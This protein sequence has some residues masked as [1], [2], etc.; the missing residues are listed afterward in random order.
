MRA[1]AVAFVALTL[2]A[3]APAPA[4]AAAAS[5]AFFAAAGD[6][7]LVRL[8]GR[9]LPAANQ[10][11]IGDWAGISAEVR[12]ALNATGG[13]PFTTLTALLEDGCAGGNKLAV[14]LSAPGMTGGRALRVATLYTAPAASRYVLF[15][16]PARLG[17]AGAEAT[18]AVAKAVEARFTQCAGTPASPGGALRLLGFESD[19]P[20][21]PAPPAP[22]RRLLVLGD[23][24]SSGDLLECCPTALGCANALPLANTLWA[25]DVTLTYGSLA[26]AALG[27]D[28]QTISWGGIGAAAG[29]VPA[30]TWP[31]LPD[32][33]P[34]TLAWPGVLAGGPGVAPLLPYN[35]SAFAPAGVVANLGTN[36]GAGGR[37]ANATFAALFVARYAAMLELVADAA[38]A[39]GGGTR[40]QLFVGVGPMTADYGAAAAAV[41]QKLGAEGFPATLLN[42]TL[43]SGRCGCGH[44]SA[45]DHAELAAAVVP[46]IRAALGW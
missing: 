15:S 11:A 45:Q 18:F 31:T 43:A 29:D 9:W 30:W 2:L 8:V 16:S 44:P 26:A 33:L 34:W 40:P 13:P 27:A 42:L 12:V 7:S 21:L 1:S 38:A 35:L 3:S 14:T 37:F 46:V 25:D 19:A 24:I 5:G 23:S 22:A 20:F 39:A 28:A 36:D 41:V 10:S 4:A 17:V 6:A 32:A